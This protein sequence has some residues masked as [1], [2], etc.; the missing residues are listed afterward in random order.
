MLD[1][2]LAEAFLGQ[3][4]ELAEGGGRAEFVKTTQP[5]SELFEAVSEAIESN[6]DF[7]FDI[8]RTTIESCY[9]PDGNLKGKISS[10]REALVLRPKYIRWS[11]GGGSM[12]F[13]GYAQINSDD[14]SFNGSP[15]TDK[16]EWRRVYIIF[17]DLRGGVI[18]ESFE[19]LAFLFYQR[20]LAISQYE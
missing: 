20:H 12:A 14:T 9:D 16:T 17:V 13:E 3:L 4:K 5:K 11:N 1:T 6:A 19:E 2:S 7:S 18:I 15:T 10:N 8:E